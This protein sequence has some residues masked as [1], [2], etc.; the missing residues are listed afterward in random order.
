[1]WVRVIIILAHWEYIHVGIFWGHVR[2]IPYRNKTGN[3]TKGCKSWTSGHIRVPATVSSL[4]VDPRVHV[5]ADH[6]CLV[7]TLMWLMNAPVQID[8]KQKRTGGGKKKSCIP[9]L[10]SQ[11]N[12]KKHVKNIHHIYLYLNQESIQSCHSLLTHLGT[13]RWAVS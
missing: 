9:L 10:F 12:Y 8:N 6:S 4:R 3:R 1:M 11:I 5:Q 13:T 2:V 7:W